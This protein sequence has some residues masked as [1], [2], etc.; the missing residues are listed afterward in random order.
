MSKFLTM[1]KMEYLRTKS[2]TRTA[3]SAY[4]IR[5]FR[6]CDMLKQDPG[7]RLGAFRRLI[8]GNLSQIGREAP[9]E[10][11]SRRTLSG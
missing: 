6:R 10:S 9:A 4:L 1:R 7:R 2:G 8:A 11:L 3:L 5:K